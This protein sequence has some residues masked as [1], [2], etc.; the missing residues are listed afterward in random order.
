MQS[1]IVTLGPIALTNS[2][3]NVLNPPTTTGG[4]N[5]GTPNTALIIRQ[6]SVVNKSAS[7]ATFSFYLGATGAS[8]AG[9]EIF[10]TGK[11]VAANDVYTLNCAQRI[12]TSQFL[13]GLASAN[14]SLVVMFSAEIFLA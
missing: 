12:D 14:T 7:A 8:A 3:A 10:G 6:V 1:K 9:T 4:T 11:S 13:V 5:C 2:A